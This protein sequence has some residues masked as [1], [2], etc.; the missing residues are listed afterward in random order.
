M[1]VIYD[2]GEAAPVPRKPS[3]RRDANITSEDEDVARSQAKRALY[4]IRTSK[5][6]AAAQVSMPR[7]AIWKDPN[8]DEY[9]KNRNPEY[10]IASQPEMGRGQFVYVIQEAAYEMRNNVGAFK[11]PWRFI[12]I[13]RNQVG[14][15][16]QSCSTVIQPYF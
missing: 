7:G 5:D 13:L 12:N 14:Q 15:S 2:F 8:R 9:Q 11:K 16:Q 6:W 10:H 1:A 3:P 4:T